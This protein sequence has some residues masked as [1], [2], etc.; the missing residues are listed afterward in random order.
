MITCTFPGTTRDNFDGK[1][2]LQL[3]YEAYEPQ[4]LSEM[5]KICAAIRE[6]W[7]IHGIAML[8]RAGSVK[9]VC[10]CVHV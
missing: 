3:E 9:I 1:R 7:A 6:K 5:K 4:A 2:V 8:H 10:V